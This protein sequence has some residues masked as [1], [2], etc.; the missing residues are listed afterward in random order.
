MYRYIMYNHDSQSGYSLIEVLIAVAILMTA[1]VAPMTV[2]VKSL[3]S[4]QYSMEQN[5]AM[6]LA[7][8]AISLLEMLRNHQALQEFDS[9][10]ENFWEWTDALDNCR[11]ADGCNFDARDPYSLANGS[12]IV[13]CSG[14]G[15]NCRLHYD[16]DWGRSVYR[17]DNSGD[18]TQFIR[19]V[20]VLDVTDAE[21]RVRVDVEWESNFLGQEQRASLHTS[22]YNLYAS[23][24]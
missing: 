8:E 20:V 18:P 2:A 24:F 14:S 19:K 3:Q 11:G 22:I 6:F 21:V 12:T 4:S 9:G 10:S 1:I 23:V 5:T 15:E 16:E 13:A 17:V 7:Q